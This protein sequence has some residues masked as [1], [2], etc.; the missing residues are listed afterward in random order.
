[1]P[2]KTSMT[3]AQRARAT[4]L[5]LAG[6]YLPPDSKLPEGEHV[7]RVD[8]LAYRHAALG[9]RPV[10]R[11]TPETLV[12]G[13]A[14]VLD[15]LG[16]DVKKPAVVK[17]V[18]LR[19]RQTLGFPAWAL[20]H[21]P[22]KAR[23]ALEVMKDFRK[24]ARRA[25]S[26]PGF[27]KE[28]IDGIAKKLARS[29]PHFLPSFYEE[30][31]RVF[32][33]VGNQTYASQCFGKAREVEQVHNLKVNEEER[34]AVFLEFALAGAVS[35]KALSAYAKELEEKHGAAEAYTHFRE[36]AI[37]RTLG[38]LPP[39]AGM[40]KDMQRLAKGAGHA[41]EKEDEAVLEEL[42]PASSLNRAPAGFWEA[43]QGALTRL[44]AR[45]EAA[46]DALLAL[47]PEPSGS[48]SGDDDEDSFFDRWLKLLEEVGA[49]RDWL[50]RPEGSA[51]GAPGARAEASIAHGKAAQW[52]A[53]ML[54][55]GSKH[56]WPTAA[57]DSLF[58]LL[59]RLAPALKADGTP[60][61]TFFEDR[62]G[63]STELEV[64]LT[65]L[66]LELGVPVQDPPKELSMDLDDWARAASGS[67]ER[68]R[69]P[70][71][72]ARDP[73]FAERFQKAVGDACGGSNFENAARG[74]S[75]M[76]EARRRWLLELCEPKE[77]ALPAL[78]QKL[79]RISEATTVHTFKEFPEALPKLQRLADG[80]EERL[81]RSLQGGVA[82]EL[83][84][85]AFEA[86]YKALD[87]DDKRELKCAGAF[88]YCVLCDEKKA[89]VVGPKGKLLEHDLKVPKGGQLRWL[90]W[91]DG[92]LLVVFYD[93]SWDQ[94]AYWSGNPKKVFE[95][96][97][98]GYP[99][100][101][102]EGVQL[103][104]AGGGALFG[105]TPVR[106]G[107]TKLPKADDNVLCDGKTYWRRVE[108]N[109]KDVLEE[110]DPLT[111]EKGRQS[112]PRFLEEF[113][114]EGCKLSLGDAELI[115][116][117][118]GIE[119]SPL[120]MKDGLL[121]WRERCPDLPEDSDEDAA[122]RN[123]AEGIDGRRYVGD[124]GGG[125]RTVDALVAL[126]GDSR[127]RPADVDGYIS[128][129]LDEYT[130]AIWDPEGK[131]AAARWQKGSAY[132]GGVPLV[133]P[134]HWW[135]LYRA[136]DEKGSAA[137]R[138]VDAALARELCLAAREDLAGQKKEPDD[139]EKKQEL[140]KTE[141]AVKK[142]LPAI[143]ERA[144]RSGVA[145]VAAEAARLL[146][147]H[148]EL[149]KMRDPENPEATMVAEE[150]D[151]ERFDKAQEV[152]G[153]VVDDNYGM[154]SALAQLRAVGSYFKAGAPGKVPES[155]FGWDELIGRLGSVV[156][157][158]AAPGTG[159]EQREQL[160]SFLEAWLESPFL[161]PAPGTLRLYSCELKKK[162]L[163]FPVQ[164][165]GS[166]SA[167]GVG[168]HE[169]NRYFLTGLERDE[170]DQSGVSVIEQCGE[171]KKWKL[172]PSAKLSDEEKLEAGWATPERLR[173]FIDAIRSRGGWSYE[174]AMGEALAART[175]M[176]YAEAALLLAGMPGF[177]TYKKNFLP[178]ELRETLGLKVGDADSARDSL[179]RIGEKKLRAILDGALPESPDALYTPLGAG[180]DDEA[181]FVARLA[182]SYTE[183]M[184][185]RIPLDPALLTQLGRELNFLW[186]KPAEVLGPLSDPKKAP[187]LNKDGSWKLE[188]YGVSSEGKGGEVFDSDALRQLGTYFL[189]LAGELPAGHPLVKQLPEVHAR[190]VKRLAAPGLL[191]DAGAVYGMNKK[192]AEA[193]VESVGGKSFKA[194]GAKKALGQDSGAILALLEDDDN[195]SVYLAFR[196]G[197]VKDWA[198]L[199][200][201][202]SQDE[203]GEGNDV[204]T[205]SELLLSA[206]AKAIAEALKEGGLAE[207]SY[208]SNPL[209]S[210]PK[211]VAEVQKK[212]KLSEDAAVYYLQLLALAA[213]T[214]A[215][216]QLWNGWTPSRVKKAGDELK[217]Q[218]LVV[219]AKRARAGR[220]HFLPCGWEALSAPNL[221]IETWKLPLY[222][223]TRAKK[224]DKVELR[225]RKLIPLKPLG[226]L[227]AEAWARV[228]KGDK[229]KFEE[230]K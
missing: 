115:P 25:K 110:F 85:P 108:R 101:E 89:I 57:P 9:E 225:L 127:F 214:T 129:D 179:R 26:K 64:D 213:P 49:I 178:T 92:E 107:D 136:R 162:K 218:K 29:V 173:A 169:G 199:R 155:S 193:L 148:E 175:G 142:L 163:P 204:I 201:L 165:D 66:A 80:I 69:D 224:G 67:K 56:R 63:D 220:A 144:L 109:E 105:D 212:L 202:A 138:A 76:A 100:L 45:S 24:E 54:E 227:F 88:P 104:L 62:W 84:W 81:A 154:G 135:H 4:S 41:I 183:V 61:R 196:P 1:M 177:R 139:D 11:L 83:V 125:E 113:V 192:K 68:P 14:S 120:G 94:K 95:P 20:V 96:E 77:G 166:W 60:L 198:T 71:Q 111:G 172:L 119:A 221:P 141:A 206:D 47:S 75:A 186:V 203:D 128:D 156:Y 207:G 36:I 157:L 140:K 197:K 39:W 79:E 205:L 176:A 97:L 130:V 21:D 106:P 40:A 133:L 42:L 28:G 8:A 158:A 59:R 168:E 131:H 149:A 126:P 78:A 70:G 82:A 33:D 31:G 219:E 184:G 51:L 99:S 48:R 38:G 185:K 191:L 35:I 93:K 86:A 73:R 215:R 50:Q 58:A 53:R 230:V 170:D 164:D 43:Y 18:A 3:D 132:A 23:F 27:A 116:A 46:R 30:A 44:V 195:P 32:I 188:E 143:S 222:G 124:L 7:D 181:S 208:P 223:A 180:A 98:E 160:L 145:S 182:E 187:A 19:R 190:I 161:A 13:E 167:W 10:V 52:F 2:A 117:P 22:K 174:K 217:K 34:K 134:L 151:E 226:A 189:Y 194:K 103:P 123:E 171:G 6:A 159:S 16:F 37:R 17:G 146:T 118:E 150:G 114:K 200:K 137:L 228:Q 229:P 65:D 211:T 5:L 102:L 147:V 216:V 90:Q 87:P 15:F 209:A 72:L 152:L 12:E 55:L 91:V 153:L 74:K 121:G 210:A 112:L 122:T